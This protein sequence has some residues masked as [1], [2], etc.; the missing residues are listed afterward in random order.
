M[1]EHGH[2]IRNIDRSRKEMP[3]NRRKHRPDQIKPVIE[4]IDNVRELNEWIITVIAEQ[5]Q[6]ITNLVVGKP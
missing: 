3:H 1:L 6:L 5:E 4:N 2:N